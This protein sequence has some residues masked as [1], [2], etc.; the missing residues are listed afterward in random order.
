MATGAITPIC[1]R[2]GVAAPTSTVSRPNLFRYLKLSGYKE[3]WYGK[4][5]A[6]AAGIF[7]D[8]LTGL[9][10]YPIKWPYGRTTAGQHEQFSV[11][12]WRRP[13]SDRRLSRNSKVILLGAPLARE[14]TI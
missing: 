8:S 7:P 9:A 3:F 12:R 1:L 14:G 4:S 5:D 11:S 2:A 6:L 13:A 10:L